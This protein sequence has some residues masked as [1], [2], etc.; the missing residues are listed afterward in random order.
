MGATAKLIGWQPLP[1]AG[2]GNF[3]KSHTAK[4]ALDSGTQTPYSDFL[5]NNLIHLLQKFSIEH[6]LKT[7]NR[8]TKKRF[9]IFR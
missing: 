5:R 7:K 3:R 9:S 8:F 2:D 1:K 6:A 4:L